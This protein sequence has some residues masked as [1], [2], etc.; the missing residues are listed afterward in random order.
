MLLCKRQ[1]SVS[2]AQL[3][4]TS[5]EVCVCVSLFVH[6]YVLNMPISLPFVSVCLCVWVL[7]YFLTQMSVCAL[8]ASFIIQHFMCVLTFSCCSALFND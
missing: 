6:K 5:I 1:G 4:N 8:N 2:P 7:V 3:V